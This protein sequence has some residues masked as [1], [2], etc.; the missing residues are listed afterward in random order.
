MSKA[1]TLI[2]LALAF[3]ASCGRR[4]QADDVLE[5]EDVEEAVIANLRTEDGGVI[6][7]AEQA[8]GILPQLPALFPCGMVKDTLLSWKGLVY[9]LTQHLTWEV[10][11]EG[12]TPVLVLFS[13]A[14]SWQLDRPKFQSACNSWSSLTFTE[15]GSPT[16]FILNGTFKR[17]GQ[18][19]THRLLTSKEY[20]HIF[21]I[22]YQNVAIRKTDHTI[23][24]GKAVFQ[25]DGT[26]QGG[27]T[28]TRKG[29]VIFHGDN[30]ATITID[31]K[32]FV[33]SWT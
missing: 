18:N 9:D 5:E 13:Q 32:S 1:L 16:N 30:T 20:S 10:V 26:I 2:L 31:Q 12:K 15:L 24:S 27:A 21:S 19:I 11:C 28:I 22:E 29:V 17:E 23:A 7:E 6:L 4:E 33:V 25:F 3:L 14:G 8:A